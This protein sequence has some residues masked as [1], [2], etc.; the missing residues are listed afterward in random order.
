MAGTE[1]NIPHIQEIKVP[2]NDFV[3]EIATRT[4]WTV[5]E[6]HVE[7]C[8]IRAVEERMRVLEARFNL[9]L[10]AIVGSGVLGGAVGAAILKALGT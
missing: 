6:K 3:L 1:T 8:P 7:T 9:L 4:A 5:I 2:L 10:G